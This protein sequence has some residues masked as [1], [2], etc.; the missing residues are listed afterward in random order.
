MIVR[1]HTVAV[2]LALSVESPTVIVQI[3]TTDTLK[4]ITTIGVAADEYGL[5]VPTGYFRVA[6]SLTLTCPL[7]AIYID[8]SQPAGKA[9]LETVKLA[10][11]IEKR[12]S[13]I[14]YYMSAGSCWA[15]LVEMEN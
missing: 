7:S 1:F 4:T 12:L 13:R 8:L 9:M 10:K 15:S 3:H 5:G 2:L 14:D 11:V 6:E